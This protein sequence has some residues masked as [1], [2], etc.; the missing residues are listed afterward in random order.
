[1]RSACVAGLFCAHEGGNKGFTCLSGSIRDTCP[2][3]IPLWNIFFF[4][5]F[6]QVVIYRP[7]AYWTRLSTFGSTEFHIKTHK[8]SILSYSSMCHQEEQSL[9]NLFF[10]SC[11]SLCAHLLPKDLIF[12]FFNGF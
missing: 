2:L 3:F 1:M 12:F 8:N 5:M 9:F 6:F 7:V 11:R 10:F 4:L